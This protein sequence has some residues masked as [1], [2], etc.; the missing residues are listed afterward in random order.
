MATIPIYDETLLP[1]L[2][3]PMSNTQAR[4]GRAT[5]ETSIS[6]EDDAAVKAFYEFWKADCNYGLDPFLI[7]LP[8]FGETVDVT[9]PAILVKFIGDL[10][11]DK[12]TRG[13]K[14]QFSL[15]ILGDV[16]Y[17][18]DDFGNFIVS[19]TGDFTINDQGDFVATGNNVNSYKEILW[20]P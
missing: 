15:E 1:C 16:D 8:F 7:P 5:A 11:G 4:T 9:R 3:Y 6:G 19:D 17:V 20:E 10:K 13:W 14:V 18:V 2:S 12:T